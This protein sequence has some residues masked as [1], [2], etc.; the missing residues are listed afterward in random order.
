M[1]APTGKP[2]EMRNFPPAVPPRPSHNHRMDKKNIRKKTNSLIFYFKNENILMEIKCN[3]CETHAAICMIV[4]IIARM[5]SY[6]H[7][8]TP[9][10][11]IRAQS[12]FS[13]K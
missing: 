8:S 4:T 6:K 10:N 13:I 5:H 3:L 12:D 7:Q 2:S 1:T 11:N 9:K